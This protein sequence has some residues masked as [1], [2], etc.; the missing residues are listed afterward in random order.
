[1]VVALTDKHG[2]GLDAS[3]QDKQRFRF[4]SNLQPFSLAHGEE[5]RALV[6]ANNDAHVRR[7]GVRLGPVGQGL[8]AAV[9]EHVVVRV[10]FNDVSVL[11]RQLLLKELRQPHFPN[12][13]KAL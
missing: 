10:D 11:H 4:A 8:V 1:M 6:L 7:H 3:P 5:M 13:A 2:V 12:E 9:R